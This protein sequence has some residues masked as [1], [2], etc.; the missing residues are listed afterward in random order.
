MPLWSGVVVFRDGPVGNY[1]TRLTYNPS[2]VSFSH[3]R[4]S[5]LKISKNNKIKRKLCLVNTLL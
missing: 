1:E 5:V 3:K 2:E 4:N